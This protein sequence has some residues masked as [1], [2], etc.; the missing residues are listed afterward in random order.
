MKLFPD[1]S[2]IEFHFT[3]TEA[4]T[5]LLTALQ[6][7]CS[8]SISLSNQQFKLLCEM[9]AVWVAEPN[10]NTGKLTRP[11]RIRR[12]KK[13]LAIHTE[14]S[15]YLNSQVLNTP[16]PTP[17]LIADETDFSVWYKPKGMLSQGSKWGIMQPC[18]VG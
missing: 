1:T 12:A 9:G 4:N 13:T 2:P 16:V 3:I 10:A 14:V 18:I 15:V 17:S 7:H 8:K 6:T 11:G 5:P